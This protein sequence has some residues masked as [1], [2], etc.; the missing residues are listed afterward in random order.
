MHQSSGGHCLLRHLIK[1]GHNFASTVV[2]KFRDSCSGAAKKEG[3]GVDRLEVSQQD[4]VSPF[5]NDP[6]Y[7]TIPPMMSQYSSPPCKK[8]I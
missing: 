2:H 3:S 5:S 1:T 8:D 4:L 7:D 6:S